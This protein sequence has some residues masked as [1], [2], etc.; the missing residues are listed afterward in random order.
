[1][2]DGVRKDDFRIVV[3]LSR[4]EQQGSGKENEPNMKPRSFQPHTLALRTLLAS[5]FDGL[6]RGDHLPCVFLKTCSCV[7]PSG[8][9]WIVLDEG[10]E[11]RPRTLDVADLGIGLE[12]DAVQGSQI[13][14]GVDGSGCAVCGGTE[15][16][17]RG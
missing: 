14:F 10:I 15:D 11:Q 13:P 8:V 12:D 2:L 1:M 9:L 16:L 17:G 5:L 7:P 3:V 6:P 4:Y